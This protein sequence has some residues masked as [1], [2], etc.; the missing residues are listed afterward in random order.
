METLNLGD[1]LV[2]LRRKKGIT[3]EELAN[4][5]GVTKA[6]VSKWET[7]Q[8]M[9]DILILPRLAAF[10][11]VTVDELIGYIPQL[12]KEQIQKIY[13]ELADEFAGK[14]FDETMEHCRKLIKTYYSCYP[15]LF[16]MSVLFLNHF[17]LADTQEK[18]KEVLEEAASLCER[19]IGDC[20][21]I[22]LCSDAVMMQSCIWLQLGK[23]Q[24]VIEKLEE[25]CSPYRVSGQTDT[26][27]LQAYKTA[28]DMEKA[29]R[30]AQVGMYTHL[31]FLVDSAI[32]FMDIRKD[33]PK[34]CEET[35]AR[36]DKLCEVYHLEQLQY[37]ETALY[38]MQAA[39]YYCHQ[40][41]N[42][43]ALSRLEKYVRIIENMLTGDHLLQHGD[44]YFDK[45]ALWYEGSDL[46][47]RAPRDKKI[48]LDSALSIF[49]Y[50]ALECLKDDP[51]FQKLQKELQKK[52]E[53]L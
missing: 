14:P 2:R 52:G 50:P 48:I 16:Q 35:I 20:R 22:S 28:G 29:D 27:L 34:A 39:F 25:I 18:Q 44:V 36:I 24:E 15:F 51:K 26:L 6:S 21:D 7:R 53:K 47:G 43:K 31:M 10:F 1:N 46:G 41:Q 19:I 42:E 4:F 9:P 49:S 5:V 40:G 45:I 30:F 32:H 3:Q 38:Q 8:S 12:G 11:D 33:D 17:M 13:Y 37:Q 23:V